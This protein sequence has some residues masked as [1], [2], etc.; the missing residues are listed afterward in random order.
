MTNILPNGSTY[1]TIS[2]R[3]IGRL[4]RGMTPNSDP[5]KRILLDQLPKIIS[6]YGKAFRSDPP[7]YR[8][9]VVIICDLDDRPLDQFKSEILDL[10]SRIDPKPSAILCLAIEEGEAWLLGDPDAVIEAYPRVDRGGLQAYV[11]DSIC[12]TWE[13]LADL[14]YPGGSRALKQKGYIEIGIQKH[15]WAEKIAPRVNPNRTQSPS[16]R[17]FVEQI[18]ALCA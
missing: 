7:E 4:P 16:F 10:L 6:G 9:H 13:K 14:L 18:S 5:K 12:G 15:Q 17:D 3:G 11:P 1:R 8:R 2:Y